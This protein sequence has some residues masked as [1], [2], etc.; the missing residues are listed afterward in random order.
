MIFM[1]CRALLA[2]WANQSMLGEAVPYLGFDRRLPA[3]KAL[4]HIFSAC[5]GTYLCAVRD[6]AKPDHKPAPIAERRSEMP[7][8]CLASTATSILNW[9]T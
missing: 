2:L 4:P 1:L 3:L 9:R 5:A 8:R 7:M 6:V